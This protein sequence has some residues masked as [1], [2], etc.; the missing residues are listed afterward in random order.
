MP[1][2]YTGNRPIQLGRG[3]AINGVTTIGN[4]FIRAVPQSVV[5]L[6]YSLR[7]ANATR[8]GEDGGARVPGD[9]GTF[10]ITSGAVAGDVSEYQYAIFTD[11]QAV[12]GG[13]SN[14]VLKGGN[15][16]IQSGTVT[17]VAGAATVSNVSMMQLPDLATPSPGSV[18]LLNYLTKAAT[19]IELAEVGANRV[20]GGNGSFD[21]DSGGDAADNSVVQWMVI[22]DLHE[23]GHAT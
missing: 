13:Y 1:K 9:P 7:H 21:I 20:L 16:T 18:V 17:M 12:N 11:C 6:N 10:T 3:V 19:A 22:S 5:L 8:L 15:L 23:A 14:T 2:I 4:V